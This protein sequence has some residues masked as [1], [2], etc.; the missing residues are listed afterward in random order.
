MYNYLC[1]NGI[2]DNLLPV[3]LFLFFFS[4]FFLSVDFPLKY[5]S[6]EQAKIKGKTF[7][8]QNKERGIL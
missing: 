2:A 7:A 4:W 8:L 1:P 5:N 3:W 6:A